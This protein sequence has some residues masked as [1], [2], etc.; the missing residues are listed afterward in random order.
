MQ[1]P[2]GMVDCLLVRLLAPLQNLRH[3]GHLMDFC[4]PRLCG[5][6]E[7]A[8]G[9]GVEIC[10]ACMGELRQLEAAPRCQRCA[11]P[12]A[13][14]GACCPY[15]QARGSRPLDRIVSLGVFR[16]PIR[17]LIHQ[18]KYHGR[19]TLA[20]FL[21]DRLL[22]QEPVKALL[23]ETEL[24]VP[25]P[26]HPWR[27]MSRGYNQAELIARRL[28]RRCGIRLRQPVIRLKNTE[29]QTHLHSRQKRLQ[30]LRDAFGVLRPRVIRGRHIVIVDDVLTTGATLGSVA[31][32]MLQ[33]EPAS[34]CGL[35]VAVADPRSGDFQSI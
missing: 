24:I 2:L 6:C 18:I 21:A 20:E 3:L 25:V 34:L 17:Q 26:L 4:Y 33:A 13:E 27:H 29:T 23:T 22:E 9:P 32:A 7:S 31:R 15:C 1:S 28:A 16:D 11:M 10:P 30:N 19:W 8:A 14:H 12:L 35:V 5:V